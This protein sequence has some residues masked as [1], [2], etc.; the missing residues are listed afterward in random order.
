MPSPHSELA[1]LP[2][3][4]AVIF[5][6]DGTLVDTVERRIEAWMRVFA[7]EGI[8]A[9]RGDVSLLIGSDGRWLAREVAGGLSDERAEAIDARSGQIYSALNTSPKVLPGARQACLALDAA[10]IP[11]AIATSSRREQVAAS[12]AALGLPR[13]PRIVD[14]QHVEHAKPAPDL[15]L[16]AAERLGVEPGACWYVGDSTWDMQAARAANMTAIGVTV[17]AAVSGAA[18][19]QVGAHV[20]LQDLR[21]LVIRVSR[22]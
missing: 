15:L 9:D 13:D 3:P 16:H 6:L 8:E 2:D 22:G 12:V 17:G 11:W 10:G 7:E 1:S 5:D 21:Q 14:G 20:V 18:L 19:G 4:G